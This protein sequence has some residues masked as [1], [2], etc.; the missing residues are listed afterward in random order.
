MHAERLGKAYQYNCCK[1]SFK[2]L[3]TERPEGS[4]CWCDQLITARWKKESDQV[5]G[6]CSGWIYIFHLCRRT[7]WND[8][9][10]AL[11]FISKHSLPIA[12][13]MALDSKSNTWKHRNKSE[14]AVVTL[15][16][17]LG[18]APLAVLVEHSTFSDNFTKRRGANGLPRFRG[19]GIIGPCRITAPRRAYIYQHPAMAHRPWLD[20]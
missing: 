8:V 11:A 10:R 5:C 16:F 14:K 15:R 4:K 18:W 6:N 20:S 17:L 9:M 1:T 12:K 7:G 13:N 2:T 3:V 19:I